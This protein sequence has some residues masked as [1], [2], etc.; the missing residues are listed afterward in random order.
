MVAAVWRGTGRLKTKKWR[1]KLNI[2]K[3]PI[4][5]SIKFAR[6]KYANKTRHL[7]SRGKTQLPFIRKNNIDELPEFRIGLLKR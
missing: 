6:K 2:K 5:N 1:P 3:V 7:K 4:R